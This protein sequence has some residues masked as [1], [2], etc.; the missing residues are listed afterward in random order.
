MLIC[1]SSALKLS[2]YPGELDY[3][4]VKKLAAAIADVKF[5]LKSRDMLPPV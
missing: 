4:I 1:R 2:N 5:P 3:L